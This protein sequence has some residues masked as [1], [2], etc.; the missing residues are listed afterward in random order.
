MSLGHGASVV[1]EGLVLH[2]DAANVKSYSGSGTTWKDLSGLGNNGTLINGV[3]YSSN[4][5]GALVFD[6]VN[7]YIDLGSYNIQTLLNQANPTEINILFAYRPYSKRNHGIFNLGPV[8][9]VGQNSDG[10]LGGLLFYRD[11]AWRNAGGASYLLDTNTTYFVSVSY[12]NRLVE[13]YVNGQFISSSSFD[14]DWPTT[15]TYKMNIGA[16]LDNPS[17]HGELY[18]MQ[19]HDR[20]LSESEVKQNFEA[21]RGRYGI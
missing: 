1:R 3:A 19:I 8:L 16:Y 10:T 9:R 13:V 2:L 18:T 15:S 6:G 14:I 7:D 5:S 17:A 21:L 20:A 12:N 4:D 11:G